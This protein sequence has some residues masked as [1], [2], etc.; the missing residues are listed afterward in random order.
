MGG[1]NR[2]SEL[3]TQL[4]SFLLSGG[5]GVVDISHWEY[6]SRDEKLEALETI[7]MEVGILSNLSA[8]YWNL[9]DDIVDMKLLGNV[10]LGEVADFG[11]CE[12]WICRSRPQTLLQ[13]FITNKNG[14]MDDA[15]YKYMLLREEQMDGA[16]DD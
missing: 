3:V 2:L 14:G 13:S 12:C 7:L 11:E 1:L 10:F 8:K 9:V 15:R 5:S 6:K 4:H 16:G